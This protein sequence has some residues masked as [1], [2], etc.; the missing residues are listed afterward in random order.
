MRKFIE[1]RK[2]EDFDIKSA[3]I[4]SELKPLGL[5]KSL[6][7]YVIFNSIFNVNIGSQVGTESAQLYLNLM[8]K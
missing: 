6:L 5:K 3:Y 2:D 4:V 7:A 1:E 8:K